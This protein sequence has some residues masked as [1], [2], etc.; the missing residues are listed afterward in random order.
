MRKYERYI[1]THKRKKLGVST[2]AEVRSGKK[3]KVM[4]RKQSKRLQQ[5]TRKRIEKQ[6]K[7][8]EGRA[9]ERDV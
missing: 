8:E 2:T 7:T 3:R 5:E 9:E 1:A 6:R 4:R